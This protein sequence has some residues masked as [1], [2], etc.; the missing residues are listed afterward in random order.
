MQPLSEIITESND[1]N[2]R[3]QLTEAAK[4]ITGSKNSTFKEKNRGGIPLVYVGKDLIL[5]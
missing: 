1:S 3:R 4:E 2:S 5:F